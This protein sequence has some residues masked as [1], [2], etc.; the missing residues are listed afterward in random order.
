MSGNYCSNSV[1]NA[2]KW[3]IPSDCLIVPQTRECTYAL[4]RDR[5]VASKHNPELRLGKNSAVTANH[6]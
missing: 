2:R 1:D 3:P 6:H 4:A 5:G